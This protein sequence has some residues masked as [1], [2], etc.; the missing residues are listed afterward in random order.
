MDKH[1]PGPWKINEGQ[2]Y[3]TSTGQLNILIDTE[4]EVV[5]KTFGENS[6]ANSKLIA[7]SPVMYQ[8]LVGSAMVLEQIVKNIH[9]GVYTRADQLLLILESMLTEHKKALK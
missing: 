6:S 3:K 1:T 2:T 5:A 8:E 4:T 7:K 9:M